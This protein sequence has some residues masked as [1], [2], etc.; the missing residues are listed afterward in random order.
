MVLLCC[1]AVLT[2][3]SGKI[4]LANN[5]SSLKFLK[6]MNHDISSVG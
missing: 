2:V 6:L 1:N 4:I 5:L 3:E